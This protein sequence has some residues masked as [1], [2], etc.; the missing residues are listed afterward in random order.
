MQKSSNVM[1][2]QFVAMDHQVQPTQTRL[3]RP[4]TRLI[5]RASERAMGRVFL[6][7]ENVPLLTLTG[8]GG[9]G[10]T[11]VALAIASDVSHAFRDGVVWV[12]LAPISEPSLI[13]AT[14]ARALGIEPRKSLPVAE[15]L[16]R[17]LQPQ[18]L[19]LV[20]DN[21]EHLLAAVTD[22]LALLIPSAPAL[23]VLA[24]SRASLRFRGEQALPIHPLP[25]PAETTH[26]DALRTN[27]AVRLFLERARAVNPG[28]VATQETLRD[29]A[30]ICRDLDGLPLA[31]E[32]A[33]AHCRAMSIATLRAQFAP[34]L[35]WTDMGPRDAPVRQQSLRNTIA[36]SQDLLT[37]L[38]QTLFRRLATFANGWTVPAAAAVMSEES[39]NVNL[40]LMER[41]VEQ[42]LIQPQFETSSPEPRFSM[43]ETIRQYALERLAASGEEPSIRRAHAEWYLSLV[44]DAFEPL[45]L[46]QEPAW[47]DRLDAEYDNA[48]AALS[49]L[50]A[51][52]DSEGFLRM[53]GALAPFW[54]IRSLRSEGRAWLERGLSHDSATQAAAEIRARA[55]WAAGAITQ[56]Q[57]DYARA[58]DV[59]TE[60]LTLAREA[61]NP[62][63]VSLALD[64]LGYLGLAEGD[65]STAATH[66]SEALF[67]ST[68][69]GDFEQVAH[70]RWELALVALGE[71]DLDRATALLAKALQES[72]QLGDPWGIALKLNSLGVTACASGD[73]S[74]ARRSF[75]ESLPLWLHLKNRENLASWLAGVATLAACSGSLKLAGRLFGTAERLR[76]E[77]SHA[78]DL[79]EQVIHERGQ[80]AAQQGLSTASYRKL[81]VEGKSL[82]LDHALHE[83]TEFLGITLASSLSSPE[84]ESQGP[85][86][87]K[88]QLT[89]REREILA[90]MCQR[91]TN[92]EIANQLYVST[93]TIESHVSTILHKLNATNRRDAAALAALHGLLPPPTP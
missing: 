56:N 91:L 49:W 83:A 14:V 78:F 62:R 47:L 77:L 86:S 30:A 65:F 34:D 61:G 16:S 45:Y 52:G 85:S 39:T 6:V 89:R 5:G 41:L 7:D 54:T 73:Y 37:N 80:F 32:L 43:M 11:R 90:L 88:P 92:V 55:L 36:W 31:L 84:D 69:L 42:S 48:R 68:E 21:C 67:L 82:S 24:T 27:P 70:V 8:P 10:K 79:P 18:Q 2:N 13:T 46:R 59:M 3:P 15:S 74:G 23:Q 76:E 26:E 87:T 50:D 81:L 63:S 4:L 58:R 44:E 66:L 19:L 29:I 64:K 40:S 51:V 93:R 35:L 38:E 25:L 75:Q 12:D 57:G 72:R 9:C 33:A 22:L 20:L 53:A 17:H 60:S 71:G 1:P 28:M